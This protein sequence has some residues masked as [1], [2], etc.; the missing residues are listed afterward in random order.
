MCVFVEMCEYVGILFT[1]VL[2]LDHSQKLYRQNVTLKNVFPAIRQATLCVCSWKCA[3]TW[4]FYFG[5]S[6]K[7]YR[8][9]VILKNVSPTGRQATMCVCS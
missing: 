5:H 8:Q 7:L 1:W 4:V 3:S 9:N 6:Q 2:F